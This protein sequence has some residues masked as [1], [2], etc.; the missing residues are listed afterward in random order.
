[1]PDFSDRQLEAFAAQV[2]SRELAEAAGGSSFPVP[3]SLLAQYAKRGDVMLDLRIEREMRENPTTRLIYSRF[4]TACSMA[5]SER[6]AAASHGNI[7]RRLV[8]GHLL[9]IV[10]ERKRTYLIVELTNGA[11]TPDFIEVRASDGRGCRVELGVPIDGIVQLRLDR[12]QKELH[13]LEK[14]FGLS[15]T[16]IYLI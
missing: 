4:L 11:R 5:S 9:R 2:A 16:E 14:L 6:A 3:A 7:E 8:D 13:L 10:S 15:D 1:M 12:N